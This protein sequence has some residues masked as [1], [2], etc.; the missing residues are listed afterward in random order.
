[1][2]RNRPISPEHKWEQIV[3]RRLDGMTPRSIAAAICCPVGEVREVIHDWSYSS[4]PATRVE[5]LALVHGRIE[6]VVA[7]VAPLARSGNTKAQSMLLKACALQSSIFGLFQPM[8]SG[9]NTT[10]TTTHNTTIVDARSGMSSTARIEEALNRLVASE[11]PAARAD[12]L[13]RELH[14]LEHQNSSAAAPVIE[15]VTDTE[16]DPVPAEAVEAAE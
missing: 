13:R 11:S 15:P 7:A 3:Q 16:R 9:V 10:N 5:A 8:V 6:E 1:M 4:L 14:R 2:A 12:R